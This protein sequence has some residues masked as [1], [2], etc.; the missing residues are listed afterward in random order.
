MVTTASPRHDTARHTRETDRLYLT[1]TLAGSRYL[2]P[3]GA[4]REVEEIT[5]T[6]PVPSTPPWVRGVM[7]LRGTI[8]AVV[9]LAHFLGLTDA[10]GNDSEALICTPGGTGRESDD[11]LLLALAVEAVSTIRTLA[12][13]AI[14]PLPVGGDERTMRYLSGFYRAPTH[15]DET[16]ELLGVLDLHALLNALRIE[17]GQG[18]ASR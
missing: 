15:D 13:D 6:T 4:V 8:I 9:D 7:N 10:P 14:L 12:D 1:C 2:L 18:G 17:Q 3:A 11:D 16:P 5:A